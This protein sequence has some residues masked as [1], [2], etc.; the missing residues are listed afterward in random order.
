[1]EFIGVSLDQC[2]V[3]L[4]G[5]GQR[6]RFIGSHLEQN[7]AFASSTPFITIS[8]GCAQCNLQLDA[9]DIQEDG[10]G[11]GRTEFIRNNNT[12]FRAAVIINGG[13]FFAGT[14]SAV[15]QLVNDVPGT[16]VTS[17]QNPY[18]ANI[19][20]DVNGGLAYGDLVYGSLTL[21]GA[22][23]GLAIK[24]TTSSIITLTPS[25]VSPNLPVCGSTD[26]GS[27]A[28]VNNSNTATWGAAVAGGGTFH[29]LAYCDGTA[30]TV[31]AK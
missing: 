19:T 18:K 17:I 10:D 29:V 26:A 11:S 3:T 24:G 27:I 31:A 5:T 25:N 14:E 6:F 21:G 16:N 12:G 13:K 22:T 1:M 4:S 7:A 23:P 9:T 2:N 20:N 15:A 28:A 30:W 8:T